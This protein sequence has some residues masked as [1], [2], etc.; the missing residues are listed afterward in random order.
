[1]GLIDPQVVQN[2]GNVPHPE[3]ELIVLGVVRLVAGAVSAGIDEDETVVLLQWFHVTVEVPVLDAACESVLH[4]QRWTVSLHMVVY[5]D[6][7]I[8]GVRHV[9]SALQ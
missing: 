8:V 9:H 2:G 1:M 4:H 6:P 5:A 3:T 7:L